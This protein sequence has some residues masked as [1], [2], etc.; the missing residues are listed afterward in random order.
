M[1][2]VFHSE[3]NRLAADP[4]A[5]GSGIKDV[6]VNEDPGSIP[7]WQI[8]PGVWDG[9]RIFQA[10]RFVT[11]MEYQH[12]AFEEFIRKVQPMVNAFGEGG[13]GYNTAIN[14]A[15]RAEF[16][17]AVYRFG[18]SMLTETVAR[19]EA[20]G[21]NKDMSLLDAF[22][23]PLAFDD[24]GT[25]DPGVAAGR[26]VRGMT[27]QTGNEID[28]F[29]TEA[30]RN[31]LLGLPLDLPAINIARAR[32]TGVPRLNAVRA[33]FYADSNN[34]ALAPYSSWTDFGF[35][36]KHRDSLTNFVAAYGKHPSITGSLATR[37]LA[38]QRLID[39]D[40][41]DL[42]TPADAAAF[43]NNGGSWT[44]N[45][46]GL[47]DIDLWMG[48]LAEKRAVFGGLLGSTFNYVFETQMEDLQFG[49]RFYYLSRTAGLNM[50][51]QLEG[52]SFAE[53]ISR[54]TDV[55]GLPADSFS[56]PDY[57]FDVGTLTSGPGSA[58][59][60]DSATEYDESDTTGE[61]GMHLSKMSGANGLRYTGPAHAVFNGTDGR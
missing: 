9:E 59:T 35:N 46:T 27:R 10:A 1:H 7:E 34:S 49:D 12:L 30:L 3:H 20:D 19:R 17:H 29:V 25:V 26:I 38:A 33:R 48:G 2:H 55:S 61:P 51:T 6:L 56:R 53:M 11:E 8:A 16:A 43:M 36:L 41:T 52:N 14:P 37:R 23:N 54:N 47:N 4:S 28:E 15:I 60:D 5:G 21:T 58:V 18:H 40:P 42:Q 39:Q 32:E 24:G 45:T 22:L 31:K 13:T 50:L 57:V 44:N